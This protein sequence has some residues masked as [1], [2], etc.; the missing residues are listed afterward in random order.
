MNPN[1][2][3]YKK[4]L[5][6][7]RFLT[8]AGS[9]GY[10]FACTLYPQLIPEV[11]A[12]LIGHAKEKKSLIIELF[13]LPNESNLS[14]PEQFRE[15]IKRK[16]PLGGDGIIV[17]NLGYLITE[18]GSDFLLQLNYAREFL[19]N[20]GMPILFWVDKKALSQISNQAADLYSQRS[21]STVFFEENILERENSEKIPYFIGLSEIEKENFSNKIALYKRQIID[22][23][24]IVGDKHQSLISLVVDLIGVYIKAGFFEEAKKL[25]NQYEDLLPNS[26]LIWKARGDIAYENSNYAQ[27]LEYYLKAQNLANGRPEYE[28]ISISI[29]WVLFFL[30]K[31]EDALKLSLEYKD[32]VESKPI[33]NH[34]E[35][36][37]AYEVLGIAYSNLGDFVNTIIYLKKSLEFLDKNEPKQFRRKGMILGNLGF[38][39]SILS[40]W[41]EAQKYIDLAIQH[42]LASGLSKSH[43]IVVNAFEQLEEINQ[44]LV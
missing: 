32:H 9:S 40:Q 33:K 44:N 13:F 24:K 31:Y 39:Y 42:L 26:S 29:I 17:P 14:L 5:K 30:E 22:A 37:N 16:M 41:Q 8:E 21:G 38:T 6:L 28:E 43:P 19:Q 3:Y 2:N 20:L 25:L 35:F 18:K 36:V 15:L 7:Y 23:K 12:Y 11:N 27:S 34:R 1:E 10:T 4:Q